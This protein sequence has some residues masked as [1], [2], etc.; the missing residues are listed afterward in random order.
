MS[1]VTALA[2][3][4]TFAAMNS[5]VGGTVDTG[6]KLLA[7]NRKL[8]IESTLDDIFEDLGSEVVSSGRSIAIPNA[9]YMK[10]GAQP[11]GARQVTIPLLK[12]LAGSPTLGAGTPVGAEVGQNLK[13]CTFYYNEYSFAVAS[14]NWGIK[15]NDMAIYGV[16]EQIQPSMSKWLKELRG[17]RIREASLR[18]Y[19]SVLTNLSAVTAHWN[20][21]WFIANT[22]LGSQPAW[23]S[24]EATF[25]AAVAA[26]LNSAGGTTGDGANAN[27]DL[28][29]LLSL[30]YYAANY[31]RIDP[32]YVGGERTYVVLIPSTQIQILKRNDPGQLG[33]IYT[34]MVR[35]N[36]DEMKYTGVIGR[37]GSLLLVEDQRYPTIGMAGASTMT[38]VYVNPGNADSRS[39]SVYEGTAGRNWDIGFLYGA[40]A[41]TEWIVKDTHFETEKQNYGYNQGNGVFAEGGIMITQYDTDTGWALSTDFRENTASMV[42]AFTTPAITA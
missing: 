17:K 39:K 30:D 11:T 19:D 36:A 35:S 26:A 1:T 27:I 12:A 24:T 5:A 42:L 31:L 28:D 9:I 22:D 23:D 16:F 25:H 18:T 40:G 3:P 37:V 15:S 21:N 38:P 34:S 8:Q 20:K 10:L 32:I 41:V 6:L 7:I 4:N 14:E 29:Y 2:A 33:D 13:Y